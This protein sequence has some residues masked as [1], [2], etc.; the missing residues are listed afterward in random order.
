MH[1]SEEMKR[2]KRG[3]CF[4]SKQSHNMAIR[5]EH[6]ASSEETKREKE[7]ALAA[8]TQNV[9]ALECCAFEEMQQRD[10]TRRL[11]WKHSCRRKIS[12]VVN[13]MLLL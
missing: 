13:V 12:M 3:D 1:A 7:V 10:E 11:H 2:N 6:D 5:W 8:V 9:Y 4:G